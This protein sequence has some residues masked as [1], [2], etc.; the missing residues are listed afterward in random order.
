MAWHGT[1]AFQR[2]WK[3]IFLLRLPMH[4]TSSHVSLWLYRKCRR[5]YL[6]VPVFPH[7]S[8]HNANI[9][10]DEKTFIK[11]F[12]RKWHTCVFFLLLPLL[13]LR[14]FFGVCNSHHNQ[15]FCVKVYLWG[16]RNEMY[17]VFR[18]IIPV[19]TA[20]NIALGRMNG[21]RMVLNW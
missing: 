10:G 9:T 17:I 4:T 18:I 21:L 14:G 15:S 13:L 20:Q 3:Q 11:Q 12:D 2:K 5:R 8:E 19:E 16:K 6:S 1:E 7:K